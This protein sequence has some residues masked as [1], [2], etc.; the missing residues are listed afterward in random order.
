MARK[1][2]RERGKVRLDLLPD[3]A[4]REAAIALDHGNAKPG[5]GP[6]NWRHQDI[7]SGDM[8]S[9]A[10]RHIGEYQEGRLEDP[11]SGAH[12][13][14]HAIGRLAILIDAEFHGRAIDERPGRKRR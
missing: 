13:L 7:Y 1:S 12:V 9:G 14:G 11:E 2:I 8:I 6:F 5:R 3:V 10:L 4:M